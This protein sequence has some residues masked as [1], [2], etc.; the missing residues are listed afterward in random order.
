MFSMP[1]TD[2]SNKGGSP[3]IIMISNH[4][5]SSPRPAVV[6]D[7]FDDSQSTYFGEPTSDEEIDHTGVDDEL[8]VEEELYQKEAEKIIVRSVDRYYGDSTQTRHQ[9]RQIE[10]PLSRR[11]VGGD[12]EPSPRLAGEVE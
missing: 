7:I 2:P 8:A 9:I 6:A 11:F 4:A 12:E 10:A 5:I 1:S 3:P